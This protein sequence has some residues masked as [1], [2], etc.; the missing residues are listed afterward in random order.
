M[1][2][3]ENPKKD[4]IHADQSGL[5]PKQADSD[6]QLIKLW[7]HGRSKHTQRAYSKD[8]LQF[9]GVISKPLNRVTLAE[10]QEYAVRLVE[11]KLQPSSIHRSLSAIKESVQSPMILVLI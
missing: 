11:S 3:P 1:H 5:V 6:E 9:M 8:A 4:M 2:S 10:L 7:L